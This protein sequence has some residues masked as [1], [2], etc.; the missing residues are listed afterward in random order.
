MAKKKGPR[1]QDGTKKGASSQASEQA[2]FGSEVQRLKHGR[3]G[4]W[5][6]PRHILMNS[7]EYRRYHVPHECVN[8]S[9]R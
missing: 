7:K 8:E 6:V 3:P 1:V 2:R 5:P 4:Q 9:N